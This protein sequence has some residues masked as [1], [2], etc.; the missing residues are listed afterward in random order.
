MWV[1]RRLLPLVGALALVVGLATPA[2]AQSSRATIAG[3]VPPWA[4]SANFK[5]ATATSDWIGFRVYLGFNNPSAVQSR[6]EAVSNP[7]SAQYGQ[8]LTPAQ[9]RQQFSPSQASVN[10][11]KTWLAGQGFSVDYTPSNNHYVQAEGTVAQAAAAF[12]T[13]FDNFSVKGL[14]LRSPSSDISVPSHAPSTGARSKRS[15]SPI[16]TARARCR[17]RRAVRRPRRSRAPM[18]YRR[19]STAAARP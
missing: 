8:Y 13:T 15:A 18:A 7:K 4:T 14:V 12:G 16:R 6:A 5:S 10:A 2:A 3:Q 9:F 11:V 1:G 19:P 17:M